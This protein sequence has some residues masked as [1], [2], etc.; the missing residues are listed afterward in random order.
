MN[1]KAEIL[2]FFNKKNL[3]SNFH[4]LCG[5]AS[6]SNGY[7]MLT[8]PGSVLSTSH[9]ITNWI[10]T[11]ILWN[12]FCYYPHVIMR[13]LRHQDYNLPKIPQLALQSQAMNWQAGTIIL[14]G[15]Q[16][17]CGAA[18]PG[19]A[20]YSLHKGT[21][22]EAKWGQ[23]SA[24]L[25]TPAGDCTIQMGHQIRHHFSFTKRHS[26]LWLEMVLRV[27]LGVSPFPWRRLFWRPENAQTSL[28]GCIW[29]LDPVRE[30]SLCS[31]AWERV[32]RAHKPSWTLGLKA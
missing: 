11:S 29:P 10:L 13:Q 17:L 4:L 2:V 5:W 28:W 3:P 27:Y 7:P 22:S 15:N 31:T 30:Q 21:Y 9:V 24:K 25:C 8:L 19:C 1:I 18:T 26:T 20:G 14:S 23:S 6:N 12:E 32:T 16:C